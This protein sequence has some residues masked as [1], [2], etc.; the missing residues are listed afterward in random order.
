MYN[1]SPILDILQRPEETQIQQLRTASGN[2]AARSE[3]EGSA[4]SALAEIERQLMLLADMVKVNNAK[5][6]EIRALR[7]GVSVACSRF[8]ALNTCITL[9]ALQ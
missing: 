1:K 6:E 8:S 2:A 7:D 9:F 3:P 4:S 5:Q